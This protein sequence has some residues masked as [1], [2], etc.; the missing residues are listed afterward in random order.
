MTASVPQTKYAM[1]FFDGQN[2]Y[3]HAMAAFGH[4]HPNYDPIKLH[5][6]VCEANGWTP[7]LVR[8]YTGVPDRSES[9]MW[10]AYW[11]NRVLAMKRA[12]I[13]VT[14][15]P[16]R[17]RKE[18]FIVDGTSQI[19]TT[20]QEKGIDVRIAL[21]IVSLARKRQFNVAVIYSQD[22]DLAEVVQEVREISIEQDR[23]I[24][25]CCAFPVGPHATSN[26]GID[27]TDWFGMDQTFYDA[28]L[29]P[30]DYRPKR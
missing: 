1:A 9:Q 29:D 26:R 27:R 19:H 23:W 11:S 2:L 5:N 28:C 13:V 14:T 22:Q 24:G 10:S 7:N 30:R 3:Q 12:G 6:A 21:D 18:K 16:I 17:Y 20:P 4:Y 15:R 25:I 8:F